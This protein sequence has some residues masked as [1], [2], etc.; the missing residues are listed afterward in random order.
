MIYYLLIIALFFIGYYSTKALLSASKLSEKNNDYDQRRPESG[1]EE[2]ENEIP[3]AWYKILSVSEDA[4]I[5]EITK[6]YRKQIG[7]YHPDRVSSLGP[8]LKKVAEEQSKL[9]NAAY[10]YAINE[11]RFN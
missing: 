2:T 3:S 7:L 11:K 6:G 8:E 4:S 9:I 10:E 1:V 5:E